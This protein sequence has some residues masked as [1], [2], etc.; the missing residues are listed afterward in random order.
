MLHCCSTWRQVTSCSVSEKMVT[1][2]SDMSSDRKGKQH[3]QKQGLLSKLLGLQ[4]ALPAKLFC[5]LR[6]AATNL[7]NQAAG[8]MCLSLTRSF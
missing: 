4:R 3:K 8:H 1:T 6:D 7:D 5:L 2:I